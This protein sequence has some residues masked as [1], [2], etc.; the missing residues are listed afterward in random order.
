MDT[1]DITTAINVWR[2]NSG[3][4][5]HSSNGWNGPFNLAMT[6]DGKINADFIITGSLLANLIKGGTLTL[7]GIDNSSGLFEL[8]DGSGNVLGYMDNTGLY[9]E[10]VSISG[11]FE[12]EHIVDFAKY[13]SGYESIPFKLVTE[14]V[15]NRYYR[16]DKQVGS[17]TPNHVFDTLSPGTPTYSSADETVWPMHICGGNLL[18]LGLLYDSN[19]DAYQVTNDREAIKLKT[20][21]NANNYDITQVDVTG[22]LRYNNV[23]VA[24]VS[25]SS[26]RYKQDIEHIVNDELDP[27]RLYNLKAK[28]FVYKDSHPLQ[29]QDM[30]GKLLPGFI[31]E[32]VEKEYPAAIIH[33]EDGQVESWDERRIIPGMLY[34]IQEQKKEIDRLKEIV[35]GGEIH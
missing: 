30:R 16:R 11:K 8:L 4:F 31:A 32:D 18:T 35:K 1:D 24:T 5:G 27:H 7:G 29:Y 14:S 17:I 21:T 3:G 28:Q 33:G 2:M 12:N 26:I 20:I 6:A 10:N 15:A 22:F 23:E 19:G 34:L 25:S 9:C 13:P